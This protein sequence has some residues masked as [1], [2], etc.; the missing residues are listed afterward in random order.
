MFNIVDG[1]FIEF[2]IL[3][4]NEEWVVIFLGK[5]NEIWY[6]RYDYWFLV[7]IVFYGYVWWQD[8]QNDV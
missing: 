3:W 8:I 5:F 6:R 4:Q 2:Y 1:G 7:G